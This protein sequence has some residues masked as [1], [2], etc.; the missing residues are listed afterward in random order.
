VIARDVERQA[1]GRRQRGLQAPRGAGQQALHV[2]AELE[3]QRE[4]AVERLGLVAVARD[5]ERPAAAQAGVGAGRLLELGGEGRPVARAAQSQPEQRELARVGLGDRGQHAGGD[6]RRAGAQL[7]A[8]E[9]ADAQAAS[10]RA[11][12]DGEADDAPADDGD[13]GR[14]GWVLRHWHLA[15]PA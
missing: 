5:D 9:H 4:L 2:E 15:S 14:W 3:A 6:A 10:R 7:A 13:V 1:H 8:L 12:G 11:P